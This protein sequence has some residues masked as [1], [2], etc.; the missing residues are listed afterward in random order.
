MT[1]LEAYVSHPS[2]VINDILTDIRN[3]CDK[4]IRNKNNLEVETISDGKLFVTTFDY[5]NDEIYVDEVS[6]GDEVKEEFYFTREE[7]QSIEAQ[8]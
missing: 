1:H 8:Y 3:E 2:K 5:V 4:H 6:F 7:L